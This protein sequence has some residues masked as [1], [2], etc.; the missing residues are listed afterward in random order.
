MRRVIIEQNQFFFISLFYVIIITFI[1]QILTYNVALTNIRISFYSIFWMLLLIYNT[2]IMFVISKKL[3]LTNILLV[4]YLELLRYNFLVLIIGL[5]FIIVNDLIIVKEINIVIYVKFVVTLFF[6]SVI[7][8]L[9]YFLEGSFY[10]YRVLWV[11]GFV[12]TVILAPL[13]VEAGMF[14]RDLRFKSLLDFWNWI[15]PYKAIEQLRQFVLLE[16]WQ[17]WDVALGYIAYLV[18]YWFVVASI[19]LYVRQFQVNWKLP[20]APR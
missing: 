16:G 3:S 20:E 19:C 9:V 14:V 7:V 12:G 17:G 5:V 10:K 15:V 11:V 1:S 6:A 8:S 4:D 13:L 2:F 18:V